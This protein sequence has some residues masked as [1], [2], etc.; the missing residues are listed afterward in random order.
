MDAT[1]TCPG[2]GSGAL[3][4]S[5]RRRKDGV[6]R[7]LFFSAFRCH[8]CGQRHFRIDLVAV[9]AVAAVVLTAGA[10]VGVGELVATHRAQLHAPAAASAQAA[11]GNG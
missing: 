9:A 7:L 11:I 5:R 1:M 10:F 2:C 4:C 8:T 6:L 3:F